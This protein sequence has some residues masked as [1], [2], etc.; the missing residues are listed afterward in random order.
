[1]LSQ[2]G[3]RVC[4]LLTIATGFEDYCSSPL[5]FEEAILTWIQCY[6]NWI[7]NIFTMSV[8][9]TITKDFMVATIDRLEYFRHYN[10]KLCIPIS[11]LLEGL[12][13]SFIQITDKYLRHQDQKAWGAGKNRWRGNHGLIVISIIFTSA[14][15]RHVFIISI[16]LQLCLDISDCSSAVR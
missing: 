11:D 15:Q 3:W 6:L 1:M 2:I 5:D 16:L 14:S 7:P 8:C 10:F 9:T 13:L 4:E 12:S